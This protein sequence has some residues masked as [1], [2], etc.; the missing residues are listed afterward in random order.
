L[1]ILF[2]DFT[3]LLFQD[4]V[5][6]VSRKESDSAAPAALLM[7]L[8]VAAAIISSLNYYWF[9]L[10]IKSLLRIYSQGQSYAEASVGKNE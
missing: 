3:F 9:G 1:C 2:A 4:A 7:G 8:C 6:E 10:M 5:A